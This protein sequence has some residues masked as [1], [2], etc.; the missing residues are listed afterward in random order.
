MAAQ[1]VIIA[2]TQEIPAA[3]KQTEKSR[4]LDHDY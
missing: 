1:V 4:I 2:S 3:E